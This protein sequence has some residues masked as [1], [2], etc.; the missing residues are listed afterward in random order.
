MILELCFTHLDSL[1]KDYKEGSRR[2]NE[3]QD[4]KYVKAIKAYKEV[5]GGCLTWLPLIPRESKMCEEE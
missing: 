1:W 5:V 4:D 3:G 2:L